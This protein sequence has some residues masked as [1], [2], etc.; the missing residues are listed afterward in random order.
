[1]GPVST[2]RQS[3]VSAMGVERP[4]VEQALPARLPHIVPRT[5]PGGMLHADARGAMDWG[6]QGLL[7]YGCN[8]TVVVVD[9]LTQQVV[10]TL[11]KHKAFITKVKWQRSQ[12][13]ARFSYR[14]VLATA[15]SAGHIVIWDVRE[16]F[17]TMVLQDGGR[18]IA[19]MS[20]VYHVDGCGHLLLAA[21]PPS[22]L[23]LW[24]TDSGNKIWKKTF[25]EQIVSF[26]FDPFDPRKLALL[27]PNALL[28]VDDFTVG[29][30]PAGSGSKFYLSSIRGSPGSSTPVTPTYEEKSTRDKL[31]KKVLDLVTGDLP[32]PEE[33]GASLQDCLQ[34]CYHRARRHLLLLLYGRELLLLDLQLLQAVATVPADKSGSP[35]TQVLSCCRSDALF[36]V[37]ES[38]AATLRAA[39]LAVHGCPVRGIEWCSLTALLSFARPAAGPLRNELLFTDLRT[40]QSVAPRQ[41]RA[42]TQP[43][44]AVRV[45][46]LKQYFIVTFG[47]QPTELWDLASLTPLRTLPGKF[48][49]LTALEWSPVHSV[50]RRA[51]SGADADAD[52]D[53]EPADRPQVKEHFVFTDPAGQMYHFSVEGSQVRDGTRIPADPGVSTV[54]GI[55]WKGDQLILGDIEGQLC[56][57]DLSSKLA[58]TVATH[59]GA[60]KKLKFAPGRGN[61]KLLVLFA[62]GVDIWDTRTDQRISQLRSPRDVIRILDC[63]WAASD[64]PVLLT[65]DNCVRVFDLNMSTSSS[66]TDMYQNKAAVCHPCLMSLGSVS[67]LEQYL[68]S[69]SDGPYTGDDQ[70]VR[71]FLLTLPAG[72]L[73]WLADERSPPAERGLV[74]AQLLGNESSSRLWRVACHYLS[75]HAGSQDDEKQPYIGLDFDLLC[76]S[77]TYK[78][79]AQERL[80]VRLAHLP[81]ASDDATRQMILLGQ[82]ERAAQAL[83]ETEPSDPSFYTNC[84]K[85][86]VL[87]SG[88][89]GS[90]GGGV[91]K[92]V[93]TSLIAAGHVYKGVEIL[94]VIG[95]TLDGCRYLQSSGLWEEAVVL[96]R[97]SLPPGQAAQV[98]GKHADHLIA[99]GREREAVLFLLS[100]G[101]FRR[102]AE[103]VRR[104]DNAL[105]AVLES[106]AD[107]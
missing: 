27:C 30:C 73:A 62:D 1:M 9:P 7:A 25:T 66:P 40:G 101:H 14:A 45:S 39:E 28:F 22:S 32:G 18:P 74:A 47:E 5:I 75:R 76:D 20:W 69:A 46:H 43:I 11:D 89:L 95:Q 29:K 100:T 2:E 79:H 19:D 78:A 90:D 55:A 72:L 93:A 92:L 36:T 3:G 85:A 49:P 84:L 58:H 24:D 71:D 42:D 54:V 17:F 35:F 65:A 81:S 12:L 105:H 50:R 104:R 44:A 4:A 34:M 80:A 60:V 98:I 70:G 37:C 91:A 86:C 102:A 97:C 53:A 77:E 41:E 87:A 94:C 63:D 8:Y 68:F 67:A 33:T 56:I 99:I 59:R 48:P 83:L 13:D 15:D 16:G 107:R 52:A 96:A 38:G 103:L 64:K 10:Q 23:V 106:V 57:W 82:T 88:S 21:H 51:Q 26:D 6:W 61:M 31:K